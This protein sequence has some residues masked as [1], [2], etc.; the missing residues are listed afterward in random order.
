MELFFKVLFW[1]TRLSGSPEIYVDEQ[2]PK[3]PSPI[4]NKPYKYIASNLEKKMEN[5]NSKASENYSFGE[6]MGG[7]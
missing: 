2:F 3:Y 4:K 5:S 1:F 6:H 7:L